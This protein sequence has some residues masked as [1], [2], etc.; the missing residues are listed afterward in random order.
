MKI[1][2]KQFKGLKTSQMREGTQNIREN[3][4]GSLRERLESK[5]RMIGKNGLAS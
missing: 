5:I 3:R 4:A 1:K 2:L